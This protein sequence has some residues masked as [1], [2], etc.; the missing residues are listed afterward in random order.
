MG[1]SNRAKVPSS[2]KGKLGCVQTHKTHTGEQPKKSKRVKGKKQCNKNHLQPTIA[3]CLLIWDNQPK[4]TREWI[5]NLL[6]IPRKCLGF[7]YKQAEFSNYKILQYFN[8]FFVTILQAVVF[9][10]RLSQPLITNL[11]THDPSSSSCYSTEKYQEF[12]IPNF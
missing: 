8:N 4:L 11:L 2:L 1:N 7:I 9:M 12:P 6:Y 3:Y 10:M 5:K